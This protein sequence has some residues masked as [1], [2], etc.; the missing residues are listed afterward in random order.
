[1]TKVLQVC[2]LQNT[3]NISHMTTLTLISLRNT[4]GRVVC[5]PLVIY[6]SKLT[7]VAR[8]FRVLPVQEILPDHFA[9]GYC[10]GTRT[11]PY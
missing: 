11:I 4:E 9:V 5:I 3:P 1:M 7:G 6:F 8:N 10:A 2:R